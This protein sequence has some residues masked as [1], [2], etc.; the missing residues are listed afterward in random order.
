MMAINTNTN[1]P[2]AAIYSHTGVGVE[3]LDELELLLPLLVFEDEADA[4][5]QEE[6]I[7]P[8]EPT[9]GH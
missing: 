4:I 5:V 6:E 7:E 1:T 2:A 8:E 3:V 9:A